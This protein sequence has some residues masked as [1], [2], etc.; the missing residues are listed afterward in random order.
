MT[1][2]HHMLSVFGSLLRKPFSIAAP[3]F[4]PKPTTISSILTENA[5][6]VHFQ[7]GHQSRTFP[8]NGENEED[9]GDSDDDE[10]PSTNIISRP[11]VITEDATTKKKKKRSKVGPRREGDTTSGSESEGEAKRDRKKRKKE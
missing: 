6:K 10:I 7:E 2:A 4:V 1:V 5:R 11:E 8:A 9:E 3:T